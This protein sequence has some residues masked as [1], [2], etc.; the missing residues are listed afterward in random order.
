MLETELRSARAAGVKTILIATDG[1]FSMD[2]TIAPLAGIVELAARYDAAVMLDDCH[3]TGFMRRQGAGAHVHCRVPDGIDILTGMLG[4]ALGDAIGGYVAG[5]A[6]VIGLLRQAARPYLFSNALL[7]MVCAASLIALDI[8]RTEDDLRARLFA[9]TN[10]WRTGLTELGFILHGSGHPIV[11]VIL[12][13]AGTA[14]AFA[15]G[16]SKR[17]VHAS[18]FFHPVVP[19]GTA[20]IRT[21]MSAAVTDADLDVSLTAFE[22]TGRELGVVA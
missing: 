5:S 8:A 18:A 20:R 2:G 19:H 11:P 15:R 14:Q 7:P 12:G 9:L 4:K 3:A 16:L 6:A 22:E 13:E 17:G 10:R 1:V 21:Q